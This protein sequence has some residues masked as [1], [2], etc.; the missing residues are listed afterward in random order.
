MHKAGPGGLTSHD[1]EL[2]WEEGP[3]F[4]FFFYFSSLYTHIHTYIHTPNPNNTTPED[5]TNNPTYQR[6]PHMY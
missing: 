1:E 2:K 3:E 4:S 6:Y 5:H